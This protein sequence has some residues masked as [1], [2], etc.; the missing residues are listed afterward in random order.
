M[1]VNTG[2]D[3][4][5]DLLAQR[6]ATAIHGGSPC[7]GK[8]LSRRYDL[9]RKLRKAAERSGSLRQRLSV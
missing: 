7:E 6:M 1:T 4:K 9:Y 2:N 3:T 8:L 5:S